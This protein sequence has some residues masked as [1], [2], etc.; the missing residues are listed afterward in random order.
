MTEFRSQN[1]EVRRKVAGQLP[2]A[3]FWL[4]T[5]GFCI[6]LQAEII[7]RIAISVGNQ[8]ITEG[9]LD[10][11]IR[12]TAFL[13]HE[14]PDLSVAERKK[15]AGRLIEQALVK[16]D[17]DL[18]RYPVPVLSDADTSLKDVKL[19]YAPESKYQQMLQQYGIAEDALKRRL[20]WQ[21]TLLHFVDF[22]F[23]PGIQILEADLKSYYDQELVRWKQEGVQ[24]VPTLED[25][26][27][28]IE[29]ILTQQRIDQALDTWMAETRK[30]I[31][32]NYL[33]ESLK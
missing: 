10:E 17:L 30:L 25:S 16:R 33:D 3:L 15:A 9:Q 18:S 12:L 1:S 7:D 22:R 5:P 19:S 29:E 6:L 32:I 4:L 2:A 28:K 11:E 27:A 24:P 26:R 13:N 21:L 8:V 23:R 14:K 20:L 31:P